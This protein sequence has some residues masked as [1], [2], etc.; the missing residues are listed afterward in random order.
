MIIP[1][2]KKPPKKQR[3]PPK[4]K[5]KKNYKRVLYKAIFLNHSLMKVIECTKPCLVW[6][7]DFILFRVS[8]VIK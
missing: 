6:Y 4:K 8:A 3:P 2:L 5:H 7:K 1:Y